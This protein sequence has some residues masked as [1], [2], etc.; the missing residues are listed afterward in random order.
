MNQYQTKNNKSKSQ[1]KK[2]KERMKDRHKINGIKFNYTKKEDKK[3]YI[4][5]RKKEKEQKNIYSEYEEFMLLQN[6]NKL[7]HQIFTREQKEKEK[8]KQEQ[9]LFKEFHVDF[10]YTTILKI[11]QNFLGMKEKDQYNPFNYDIKSGRMEIEQ[12]DRNIKVNRINEILKRIILHFMKIKTKLNIK[13]YNPKKDYISQETVDEI[14]KKIFNHKKKLQSRNSSLIFKKE[15]NIENNEINEISNNNNIYIKSN[16]SK[17]SKSSIYLNSAS[18]RSRSNVYINSNNMNSI[19]NKNGYI[20]SSSSFVERKPSILKNTE[21][22]ITN[23]SVN[24][25]NQNPK[26]EEY[27]CSEDLSGKKRI[28]RKSYFFNESK[29]KKIINNVKE[30]FNI[31]KGRKTLVSFA[32]SLLNTE[33][34]LKNKNY[35]K[36]QKQNS[37]LLIEDNSRRMGLDSFKRQSSRCLIKKNNL[38][39]KIFYRPKSCI[40]IIYNNKSNINLGKDEKNWNKNNSCINRKS[41]LKVKN[42][43]LYT[44]KIG[45]LIKEYNRIKKSSKKLKL[46]YKEKHFSTY[47]EIDNIIKTKEDMLMFLLKQKFFNCR[48][49][50]KIIKAPN[51]KIMFLNKMKEYIDL[52]EER[53]SIFIN[54]ERKLEL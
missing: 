32:P 44:T 27:I 30:M 48:F 13:K 41:H 3:L 38:K 51:P 40:N 29:E 35:E 5:P 33:K 25:L 4:E 14:K 53:P 8:L 50:Q 11:I 24:I 19:N 52:I 36:Y 12:A 37:T 43:P 26:K 46:N 49:P 1:I 7:K 39:N 31:K 47:E 15:E 42:L 20:S 2:F 16:N 21:K 45:D 22:I 23:N 9:E 10:N 34:I 54:F 28:R 18:Q 6:Y 17:K